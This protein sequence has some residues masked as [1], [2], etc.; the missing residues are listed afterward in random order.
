MGSLSF[1][2]KTVAELWLVKVGPYAHFSAK[3]Y[4][5]ISIKIDF[6]FLEKLFFWLQ[7]TLGAQFLAYWS[8]F[9]SFTNVT[10]DFL[11]FWFLGPFLGRRRSKNWLFS[12]KCQFFRLLGPQKGQKFQNLKNSQ[13]TFVWLIKWNH[14]AKN[15]ASK[16]IWSQKNNI[17]R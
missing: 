10:W 8:H 6:S 17:F 11:R 13:V 7:I 1:Q 14:H 3:M 12:E 4:G 15:G 2:F 9:M 5:K 16:M